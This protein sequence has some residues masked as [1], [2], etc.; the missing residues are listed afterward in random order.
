MTK[1]LLFAVA[2]LAVSCGPIKDP[3]EPKIEKP[4]EAAQKTLLK[5][6]CVGDDGRLVGGETPRGDSFETFCLDSI[7]NG[8]MSTIEAVCLAKLT[9]CEGIDACGE[10]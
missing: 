7:D 8:S 1:Y 3:D 5:L 10:E 6:E 4:C 2:A 9:D